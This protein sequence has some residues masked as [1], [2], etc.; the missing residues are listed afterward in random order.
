MIS[1]VLSLDIEPAGLQ[2]LLLGLGLGFAS[3]F[4]LVIISGSALITEINVMLPELLLTSGLRASTR[5]A[6][7]WFTYGRT[8]A[9]ST[10]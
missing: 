4:I 2:R 1:V 5:H 9:R 3:G 6:R 10:D 8:E 7:F